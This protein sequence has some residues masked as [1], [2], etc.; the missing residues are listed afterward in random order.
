MER[1][2]FSLEEVLEMIPNGL[3]QNRLFAICGLAF[4]TDSLGVNLLSFLTTC[5]AAEW[6]LSN[7]GQAALTS[8]VFVGIIAGS[9]FWGRFADDHG[10]KKTLLY[11]CLMVTVGGFASAL[12]PSYEFLVISRGIAGFGIGGAS[13]PFDLLAELLPVATRSKYLVYMGV[14]WTLGSM[15]VSGMAWAVLPTLGWRFLSFITTVPV[16]ATTFIAYIYLPE[17]PRWLL[18]VDREP[19]AIKIIRD[20]ALVNNVELPEFTLT[21]MNTVEVHGSY[22]ELVDTPEARRIT[23]PLWLI[24]AAVG[25][26][27]YGTILFVSRVYSNQDNISQDSTPQCEFNYAAIFYN[28]SAEIVSVFISAWLIEPLGRIKSQ[29]VFYLIG[30]V[31]V[32]CMG[33][34]SNPGAVLFFALLARMGINSGLVSI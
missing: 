16:F 31:S 19:D 32:F 1:T 7:A 34:T 25:F 6:K 18:E 3:F 14:F 5:A 23:L 2:Q 12:A 21:L 27:Y 17:S 13:I 30:G 8:I 9:I 24:W 20:A 15:L 29:S 22:K 11:S 33:V 26:S 28:A 10:R 4:M